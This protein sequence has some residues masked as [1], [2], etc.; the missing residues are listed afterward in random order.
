MRRDVLLIILF[1]ALTLPAAAPAEER[2]RLPIGQ[3]QR[4]APPSETPSEAPAEP[5][6]SELRISPEAMRTLA[7]VGTLEPMQMRQIQQLV[8]PAL[9]TPPRQPDVT[10][11]YVPSVPPPSPAP[12]GPA[13]LTAELTLCNGTAQDLWVAVFMPEG[14][15]EV[16]HGAWIPLAAEGEGRCGRMPAAAIR[17]PAFYY[18][19]SPNGRI[20]GEA[21]F[22]FDPATF[23]F[24]PYEA[25]CPEGFELVGFRPVALDY[26]WVTEEIALTTEITPAG[27]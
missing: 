16:A 25:D 7:G 2:P 4:L 9:L 12:G 3:I 22:C 24:L 5:A 14:G 26:P 17:S 11:Q 1:P 15:E 20:E 23:T 27:D 21:P 6:P 8:S 10:Y 13:I 18:G 19:L